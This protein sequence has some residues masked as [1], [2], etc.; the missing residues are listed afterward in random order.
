L[1][2]HCSC[3]DWAMVW[4]WFRVYLGRWRGYPSARP[5]M[6][7]E[8][9]WTGTT[10]MTDF[11]SAV[12]NIKFTSNLTSSTASDSI[13]R[14]D[15][16]ECSSWPHRHTVW[17]INRRCEKKFG[18]ASMRCCERNEVHLAVA[19]GEYKSSFM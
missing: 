1:S 13:S 2:R 17:I 19:K 10:G 16:W 11:R 5:A 7:P 6:V 8:A 15:L 12:L 14:F 3:I 4:N 9:N 18:R